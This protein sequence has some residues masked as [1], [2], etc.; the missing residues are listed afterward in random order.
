MLPLRLLAGVQFLLDLPA[1]VGFQSFMVMVMLLVLI[2]VWI[3]GSRRCVVV[4]K[5]PR[6]FTLLAHA[7]TTF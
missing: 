4:L 7:R 3:Q 2:L 5:T 1:A 6:E